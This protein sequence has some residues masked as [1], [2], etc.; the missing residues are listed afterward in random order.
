[1][2]YSI[3][4]YAIALY[5]SIQQTSSS[6]HDQ[7]IENF[8]NILKNNGDLAY[9]EQIIQAYEDYEKR[10]TGQKNVEITTA[11]DEKLSKPL[12]DSLNKI[13]G[14]KANI[15]Q[16]IDE[17]L[18]GG[19]IIRVEDTLVDASIKTQLNKLNHSLKQTR[20]TSGNDIGNEPNQAKEQD[21]A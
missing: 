2:R 11:K 5:D 20:P 9:Y 7:V 3:D 21:H 4:Q 12:L 19:V 10:V 14:A 17:S 6:G 8:L 1:M 13:A 16:K 15:S 18:V